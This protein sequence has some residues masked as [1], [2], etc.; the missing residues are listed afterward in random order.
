MK[1][2][3]EDK[4][5]GNWS[6]AYSGRWKVCDVAPVVEHF[7]ITLRQRGPLSYQ[8]SYIVLVLPETSSTIVPLPAS[9][10]Q[11]LWTIHTTIIMYICSKLTVTFFWGQYRVKMKMN[12][13]TIFAGVLSSTTTLNA[14][15][16][17]HSLSV[18][19]LQLAGKPGSILSHNYTQLPHRCAGKSLSFAS[20]T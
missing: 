17:N 5:S 20:L 10:F 12:F 2:V 4:R 14:D 19:K 9:A 8:P 6:S 15:I 11:Y 3:N 18:M 7:T 13:R 16:S 1:I